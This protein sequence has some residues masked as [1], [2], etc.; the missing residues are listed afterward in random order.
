MKIGVKTSNKTR[1]LAKDNWKDTIDL[2]EVRS[3]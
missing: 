3:R 2:I 1:V